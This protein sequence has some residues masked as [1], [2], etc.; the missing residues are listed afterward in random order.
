MEGTV[1]ATILMTGALGAVKEVSATL[2]GKG[3]PTQILRP[4]ECKASS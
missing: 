2:Q 3:I 4:D 1:E